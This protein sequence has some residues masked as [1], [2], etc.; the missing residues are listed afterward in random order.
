[1]GNSPVIWAS[2]LQTEVAL[3]TMEAE[4]I[5]LSTAMRALLPMRRLHSSIAKAFNL[6]LDPKSQVSTVWEDN[7]A[8]QTLATIDPPRLTPRSKHIAVKYHWFWSHLE[9]GVI[10]MKYIESKSQK[11]DI[12]TK[13]LTH[14]KHQTARL[15]TMGW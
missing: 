9:K 3:S 2:K 1:M 10:E 12:L 8:A 15:L 11:A 5:A 7:Q 13:P 4:Y 14:D 6:P